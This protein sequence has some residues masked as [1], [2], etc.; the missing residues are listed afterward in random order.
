MSADQHEHVSYA[1]TVFTEA[2][3]DLIGLQRTTVTTDSGP[4]IVALPS[5]YAEIVSSIAG[6]Q[7]TAFG[8]VAR[9]MP[10]LWVDAVDWLTLVDGEVREWTPH[11]LATDTVVRLRDLVEHPWRPQDVDLLQHYTQTLQIWTRRAHDLL[12]PDETHRWELT[13]A[14]PACNVK[15]VHRKDSAGDYVRQAALQITADGCKCTACH[16]TWGPQYFTHLA[17][18]LG[19]TT[20][21]GV[22]Q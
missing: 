7:G 9:S 4:R 11:S 13:A 5:R 10:P 17:A 6:A 14:C 3:D 18:V 19:C 16:T 21:E 2:V 8:G 22:L 15:T 1:A 20:P 12:N